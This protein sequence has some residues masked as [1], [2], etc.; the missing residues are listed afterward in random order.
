MKIIIVNWSERLSFNSFGNCQCIGN[1]I[2]S[3]SSVSFGTG[4]SDVF[5][6]T[7]DSTALEGHESVQGESVC[8]FSH[9]WFFLFTHFVGISISIRKRGPW[10]GRNCFL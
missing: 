6:S 5:G 2:S 4:L 10:D 3:N 9:V 7:V 8:F 1:M